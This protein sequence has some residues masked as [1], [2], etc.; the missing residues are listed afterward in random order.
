M[1]FPPRRNLPLLVLSCTVLAWVLAV[2][3]DLRLH[4]RDFLP[5]LAL[6]STAIGSV[7]LP[8]GWLVREERL[9]IREKRARQRAR[10]LPIEV[11]PIKRLGKPP[12]YEKWKTGNRVVK[13]SKRRVRRVP[14]LSPAL[15][16]RKALGLGAHWPR[17]GNHR[18]KRGWYR[19]LVW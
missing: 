3:V 6:G 4:P 12:G 7:A 15:V 14:P 17:S 5:P 2:L 8:V 18:P 19:R 16:R 1:T 13:V 11:I 9:A 10:H